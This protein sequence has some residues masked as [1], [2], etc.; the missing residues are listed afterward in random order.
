MVFMEDSE[1]AASLASQTSLEV[2]LHINFTMP[3]SAER[4]S[5]EILK[6]HKR[7]VSYLTKNKLAQVIYNPL[8][9]DSFHHL[10]SSQQKSLFA[11]MEDFPTFT[12]ATIICIS[13]LICC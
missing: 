12:M 11:F 8:L 2:G 10:F 7:V 1:R 4:V 3:F 13:A 9:A 5:P 6:H